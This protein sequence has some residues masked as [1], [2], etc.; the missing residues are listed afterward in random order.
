MDTIR[1][2]LSGQNPRRNE[3]I[4]RFEAFLDKKAISGYEIEIINVLENLHRVD[5][6]QVFATPTV[7]WIH[8]RRKKEPLG[9]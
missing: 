7:V 4:E 6:D 5:G 8:L 9:I 2:Y 3:A 1:F